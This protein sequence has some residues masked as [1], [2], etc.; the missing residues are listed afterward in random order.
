MSHI[1]NGFVSQWFCWHFGDIVWKLRKKRRKKTKGK[2]CIFNCWKYIC[3]K[4]S[5]KISLN[6]KVRFVAIMLYSFY[7]FCYIGGKKIVE[8]AKP[9]KNFLLPGCEPSHMD[10]VWGVSVLRTDQEAPWEL[11]WAVLTNWQ[12][13]NTEFLFKM[14]LLNA[15]KDFFSKLIC[16]LNPLFSSSFWIRFVT[17]VI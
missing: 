2:K 10:W 11:S 13:E 16:L 3:F 14:D 15:F 17:F 12:K 7:R 8:R 9:Q 4:A 6:N 1:I 5:Y